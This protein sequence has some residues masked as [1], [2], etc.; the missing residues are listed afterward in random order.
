MSTLLTHAASFASRA[1][2]DAE[3]DQT[4]IGAMFPPLRCIDHPILWRDPLHNSLILTIAPYGDWHEH[5]SD[6]VRAGH[7]FRRIPQG[8]G[9]YSNLTT[10][11]YLVALPHAGEAL[12]AVCERILR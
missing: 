8:L 5:E 12:D 11:Q 1:G 10:T 4:L 9:P 3:P 7:W 6:L 2:L